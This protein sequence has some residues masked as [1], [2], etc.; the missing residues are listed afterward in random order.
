MLK[1]LLPLTLAASAFAQYKAEPAG[2]PPSE[3]NP[4]I[5]AVLQKEGTK[6]VGPNGPVAEIWFRSSS[7]A[8]QPNN[9]DSVTFAN[10]A[11]GTLMGAVRFPSAASDRRGQKIQPGIYTMRFSM[12]PQN[13]DHQ[14]VEPQRDFLLLV[15]AAADTD[16]AATPGF[17]ALAAMSMKASGTPHPAVFSIWKADSGFQPGISMM[18]EHDWVLQAKIGDLPIAMIVVGQTAH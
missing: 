1:W 18:G 16:A 11:Q 13:G 10:V 5:S 14:G 7:P 9:E 17:K 4:A 3:L 2:G 6:V 15:P 8:G 12:F